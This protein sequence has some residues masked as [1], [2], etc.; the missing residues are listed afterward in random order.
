MS[1]NATPMKRS[2]EQYKAVDLNIEGIGSN[3]VL[4]IYG[5]C[6]INE[7]SFSEIIFLLN[8]LLKFRLSP[9]PY[10]KKTIQEVCLL[11]RRC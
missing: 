11:L 10:R 4:N 8:D 2:N 1:T 9:R 6:T 3:S 7:N 5:W